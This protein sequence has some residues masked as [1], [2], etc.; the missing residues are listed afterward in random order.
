MRKGKNYYIC[1]V[2]SIVDRL[3][4]L[5]PDNTL[6]FGLVVWVV[7]N[8]LQGA[9][10]GLVND[11]AYYHIYAQKLAWGYFD[12]PPMIALLIWLGELFAGTTELGMRLFV[13]VLQ[14]IYLYL[15]WRAIRPKDASRDDAILYLLINASIVLLQA[16]GFIA[17][18]DAPLMFSTALFFWAYRAFVEERDGAW[19]W[20]AVAM[21]A[22]AYSKYQGALVVLF[23]VLL[24][25][26]LLLNPRFWMSGAVALLLF[27]PHLMWQ[28]E[29]DLPSFGYH[30]AERNRPFEWS[31]VTEY[32]LNII[33][34]FNPFFIPLWVQAY[35]KVKPRDTFERAL[36]WIPIAIMLFFLLSS[37]RGR[38]QPQWMIASTYG[39][40]WILFR[41]AR[42]HRRTRRYVVRF[43]IVTLIIM[44]LL[45]VE[46][47]FNIFGISQKQAMY[48]NREQYGA[49]YDVAQGRP[50]I[51]T[52][53]YTTAS[54]Y[55]FYT[56]GEGY[57]TPSLGYRTHQWEYVDDRAFAGREVLVEYYPTAAEREREPERYHS[58]TL[59]NG[60]QLQYYI[61]D[62]Y[63][64]LKEIKIESVELLPAIV[65]RGEELTL[66]L[67]I[68]NPYPEDIVSDRAAAR[69]LIIFRNGNRQAY[70]YNLGAGVVMRG[71]SE[72]IYEL[73]FTPPK[74]LPA[75]EY[76]VGFSVISDKMDGWFSRPPQRI[77]VR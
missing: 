56:E 74:S 26:K 3:R 54:K 51:F 23:A 73:G 60:R 57:C 14:P 22:M 64:P 11:E 5:S 6:I 41:Y 33:A 52:G 69:L 20:L 30:L 38:T 68:E 2:K 61:L 32:L 18:P 44:A 50:V 65:T 39:L 31:S 49:I 45:R 29:N 1:R 63:T 35:R 16:Y 76:Q 34:V 9:L 71:E 21:A 53:S 40:V 70:L 12:H 42:E 19:L 4:G 72:G 28:Y 66:R 46:I 36:K 15:F 47:I 75:G 37:A 58:I 7:L 10:S 13:V 25:Y 77:E 59:P 43:A 24:N 67:S 48:G 55:I 62:S 27:A 8:L 17:V